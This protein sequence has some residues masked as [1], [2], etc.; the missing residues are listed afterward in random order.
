[1]TLES[2]R[3]AGSI[4]NQIV[5]PSGAEKLRLSIPVEPGNRFQNFTVQVLTKTNDVVS[6]M[7]TGRPN[8]HGN[9]TVSVPTSRLPAGVYLVRL[10]GSPGPEK[11]LLAE[12]DLQVVRK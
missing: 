3:A 5:V 1:V 8:R 7:T 2:S 10:Y 11:E 4:E 9:L 12:Y 6:T